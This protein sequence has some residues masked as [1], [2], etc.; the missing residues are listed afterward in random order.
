MEEEIGLKELQ[1]LFQLKKL[2]EIQPKHLAAINLQHKAP[3]PL[4]SLLP[5]GF[6]PPESWE[7]D[8]SLSL[9][10]QRSPTIEAPSSET[11]S[12]GAAVPGHEVYYLRKKELEFDSKDV[13]HSL[14]RAAP[15]PDRKAVRVSHFRK[16]WMKLQQ[17][18][19]YWD[20]SQDDGQDDEN[21][22]A[23]KEKEDERYGRHLFG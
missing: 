14:S 19:N 15:N 18:G 23:S 2:L 3:V 6:L 16:F 9:S 8:P 5:S 17:V 11:L 21:K 7:R 22:K 12:N 13:Y 10:G 1:R 20:T 4:E